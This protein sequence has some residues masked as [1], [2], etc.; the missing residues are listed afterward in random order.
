[1]SDS[2]PPGC[3]FGQADMQKLVPKEEKPGS[4]STV[5][6]GFGARKNGNFSFNFVALKKLGFPKMEAVK[7]VCFLF[8]I[9]V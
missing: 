1:M 8:A 3:E 7:I 4:S 5:T 2:L 6:T 9:R